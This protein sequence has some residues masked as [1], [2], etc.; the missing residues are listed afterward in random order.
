MLAGMMQQRNPLYWASV[1]DVGYSTQCASTGE[2]PAE[3]KQASNLCLWK[4]NAMEIESRVCIIWRLPD[5]I[6]IF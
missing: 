6:Y 1:W 5:L 2:P 4:S 3:S